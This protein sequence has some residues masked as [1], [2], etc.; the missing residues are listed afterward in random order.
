MPLTNTRVIRAKYATGPLTVE[1]FTTE[2]VAFDNTD[3]QE[4]EILLRILYLS[5]DPFIRFSFT[6][7]GAKNSTLGLPVRGFGTAEVVASKNVEFPVSSIVTGPSIAWEEYTVVRDVASLIIIPDARN[8][9]VPLEAYS[10]ALGITGLTAWSALETVSQFNKGDVVFVSSAA[11]PVGTSL[12]LGVKRR[13]GFV[14]GSAGSDAKVQFL[15]NELKLDAAFNYKTQDTATELSKY[16]PEGLD[17]YLDLVGGQTLDIALSKMK[18]H[19]RIVAIGNIATQNGA[20]PY[21][22]KNLSLIISKSL[23]IIGFTSS[24]HLHRFPEFWAAHTP[25]ILSGDIKLHDKVIKGLE[26]APQAFVDYLKGEYIGKVI[27]HVASL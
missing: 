4:G 18:P 27:V 16:A 11:G 7:F 25:L 2:A 6:D 22:T 1:N 26:N 17:H 21:L 3:L 15:L 20:A 13:G 8:P 12:A 10:S 14:I 23:Q 9:N 19:G 5:L 24:E